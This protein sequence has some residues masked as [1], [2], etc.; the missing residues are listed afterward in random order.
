MVVHAQPPH[1]VYL[2]HIPACRDE[3]HLDRR[4]MRW[5]P[6]TIVNLPTGVGLLPF[7]VP[8]PQG[9]QRAAQP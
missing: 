7:M 1:L 8:G 5:E 3:G 4:L 6:E 2:S 9:A